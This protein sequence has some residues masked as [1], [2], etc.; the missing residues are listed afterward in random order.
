[1][2]FSFPH[3]RSHIGASEE[4]H[5][6]TSRV[7][8]SEGGDSPPCGT[9]VAALRE[10]AAIAA[11]KKRPPPRPL[12]T[13]RSTGAFPQPQRLSFAVETHYNWTHHEHRP[14]GR[15]A[16][17]DA[18]QSCIASPAVC[19]LSCSPR[20]FCGPYPPCSS[21]KKHHGARRPGRREDGI[22]GASTP[23][24]RAQHRKCR[25]SL[26]VR[27]EWLRVRSSNFPGA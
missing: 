9:V 6:Q 16:S 24:A 1:M 4:P 11:N 10:S 22:S 3:L 19:L 23:S 13:R 8:V 15:G 12:S 14:R 21:M 7:L 18:D 2:V 5:D 26:P 27:G 25:Q 17:D 20:L